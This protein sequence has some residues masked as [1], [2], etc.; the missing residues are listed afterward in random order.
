M[1]MPGRRASKFSAK[2]RAIMLHIIFSKSDF[3]SNSW[4]LRT[5]VWMSTWRIEEW[6]RWRRR[7]RAN[8]RHTQQPPA[9]TPHRDQISRSG[10]TPHSDDS[11]NTPRY[12]V[13]EK[14]TG[15]FGPGSCTEFRCGSCWRSRL[16]WRHHICKKLPGGV[17]TH[18]KTP[19]REVQSQGLKYIHDYDRGSTFYIGPWSQTKQYTYLWQMILKTYQAICFLK[20][21]DPGIIPGNIPS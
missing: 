6:R 9:S 16:G 7:R 3:S 11:R 15:A 18:S 1:T 21:K 5:L 19:I 10:E 17:E 4:I 2:R 14:S 12:Q 8:N 13:E 20:I